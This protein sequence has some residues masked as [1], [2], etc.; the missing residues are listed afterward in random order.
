MALNKTCS[1][2]FLALMLT[3]LAL[4][5]GQSSGFDSNLFGGRRNQ[6]LCFS[7]NIDIVKLTDGDTTRPTVLG[8]NLLRR[9]SFT[10]ASNTNIAE[11]S[12]TGGDNGGEIDLYICENPDADDCMEN[13][14]DSSTTDG[15]SETV[16]TI[17]GAQ[18]WYLIVKAGVAPSS[19]TIRCDEKLPG[20]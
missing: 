17:V 15:S 2:T 5:M 3:L 10:V 11:C 1:S 18:T 16:S 8:A 9:Y 13:P 6:F 4:S 12:T 7:E 20:I 14:H 19:Y